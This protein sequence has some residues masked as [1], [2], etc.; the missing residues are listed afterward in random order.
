MSEIPEEGKVKRREISILVKHNTDDFIPLIENF[1][2]AAEAISNFKLIVTTET[3]RHNVIEEN[4]E[5]SNPI[6]NPPVDLL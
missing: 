4:Q 1:K 3:V 2:K 6:E 5:E